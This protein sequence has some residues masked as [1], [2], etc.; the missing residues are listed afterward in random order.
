MST[1]DLLIDLNSVRH[2]EPPLQARKKFDEALPV[3]TRFVTASPN[4]ARSPLA[5]FRM[6]EVHCRNEKWA[7]AVAD[8]T[9]LL[10]G[11]HA[12]AVFDQ[13]WYMAGDCHFRLEKWPKAIEA[14]ETFLQKHPNQANAAAARYNLSLAYRKIDKPAQSAKALEP[15]VNGHRENTPQ[16]KELRARALLDL[17]RMQYEAENYH[18]ALAALNQVK[19]VAEIR[20]FPDDVLVAFKTD[21]EKVLDETAAGDGKFNDILG[22]WREFRDAVHAWHGLAE[23]SMLHAFTL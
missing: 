16:A 19:E 9:A 12:D 18:S 20:Q 15:F 7:G 23:S 21:F 3:Y 11:K 1:R 4:H 2:G 13:A 14:L 6:A 5:R 17:G 22:P 10:A 8:L